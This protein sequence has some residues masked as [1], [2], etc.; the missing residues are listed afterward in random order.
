MPISMSRIGW[1][2]WA[3]PMTSSTTRPLDAEGAELI[4]GY[5][6]LITGTHPEYYSPR[7]RAALEA[8]ID[9]GGG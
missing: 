2:S 3:S 7:M 4:A 9:G 6:C 5:R 8:F 1:R